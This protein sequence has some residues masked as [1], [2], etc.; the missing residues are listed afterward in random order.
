MDLGVETDRE[1]QG[2]L[3]GC[4]SDPG[5]GRQETRVTFH[6]CDINGIFHLGED[7]YFNSF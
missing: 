2:L 7:A 4:G 5:E 6:K 3:G 1:D